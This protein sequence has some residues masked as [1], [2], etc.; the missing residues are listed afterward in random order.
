[1]TRP[2]LTFV[3]VAAVCAAVLGACGG[4]RHYADRHEA[5]TTHGARGAHS[6]ITE[7]DLSTGLPET[8]TS[9]L[10]A[11]NSVSYGDLILVLR[12]LVADVAGASEPRGVFVR[13]GT[14]RIGLSRALE[15][16]ALLREVRAIHPVVCHADEYDNA[17]LLL[18][19]M[20]CTQ[21]WVSPAGGVDAVGIAAQLVYGARLLGR[22]HVTADLLQVGK[23]KGAEEPFTRDSPS[24]EARTSLEA[25]LSGLRAAWL[26]GIG[27]G[28]PT[29][30]A[31]EAPEEGP[32]APRE[33]IGK[34][35]INSIGYADDAR[36]AATKAAGVDGTVV[37]FGQ[38]SED[39]GS[40]PGL[41]SMLRL[42]A[43]AGGLG[44]PHI[45]VLVAHGAISTDA[46]SSPFGGR[47]GI[48]EHV[49]GRAIS[50]LTTD[51]T[52]KAVVLRI[53]SPGGSA[54]A[55]DL[56]WK[57]LM[58]LRATKKLVI[59][60][61]DMAASGGYYLA[62]AGDRIFAEPTSILGSIG[63]VGG[64]LVIGGALEAVGIHAE[65]IAP[66]AVDQSGVHRASYMS[67]LTQWDDA[68]R[69]RVL[70]SVTAIYELFLD[71][72]AEGRGLPREKVQGFAEGQIFGGN[73]AKARGLVDDLGGL[74]AAIH[75]AAALA[76]LPENTPVELVDNDK[77]L[78]DLFV[79]A[80]GDDARDHRQPLA[81]ATMLI[82][83]ALASTPDI[84]AVDRVLPAA[85]TFVASI[86]PLFE[87]K[88]EHTACA[89]PFALSVD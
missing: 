44:T 32:Y 58:R 22:L 40:S 37:R 59:S 87:S 16:G 75:A 38:G 60:V 88:G 74:D 50:K 1:M 55:S 4:R 70:A 11:T 65:T 48:S 71:R 61:G 89:M 54:L 6:V 24:P 9:S 64:K 36:D 47:D 27:D 69:Q 2:R 28:R 5:P 63:V 3:T 84:A 82:R 49:L 73:D 7:L 45:A 68:T 39:A 33:A 66:P 80:D 13:L 76:H 56:L 52:T 77:G 23:Y 51:T 62:C 20:G 26:S 79:D 53:N 25:T 46:S 43:G 42:L 85:E 30:M 34:G 15:V 41:A 10:F 78:L 29:W 17:A 86:W 21:A 67:A 12:K 57:K 81:D 19:A 18:A 31:P 8:R 83:Q 14:A 72:V 35:L